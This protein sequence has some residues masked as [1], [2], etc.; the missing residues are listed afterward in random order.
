[1]PDAARLRIDIG[2]D[3]LSDEEKATLAQALAGELRGVDAVREVNPSAKE[4]PE[5]ARPIDGFTW[6][7]LILAVA[8]VALAE[9]IGFL[10]SWSRRAG[11]QPV[12]ISIQI[13]RRKIE[14]EYNPTTMT[15]AEIDEL[16]RRLRGVIDD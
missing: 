2:D 3:D 6:G 5:G 15:S 12:K 8:P 10:K 16:A 11:G 13:G 14:G 4:A 1:M 9:L 7:A